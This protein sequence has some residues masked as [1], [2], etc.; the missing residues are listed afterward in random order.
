VASCSG[1]WRSSDAHTHGPLQHVS[2]WRLTA[3]CESCDQRST[4]CRGSLTVTAITGGTEYAPGTVQRPIRKMWAHYRRFGARVGHAPEKRAKKRASQPIA[5]RS[6]HLFAVLARVL[7]TSHVVS[8]PTIAIGRLHCR[9]TDLTQMLF[10]RTFLNCQWHC[11]PT[12][13][14]SSDA[15]THGP[16]QHVNCW[17][18]DCAL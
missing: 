17:R 15:H 6:C 1:G 3:F 8:K 14:C 2:C 13:W 11:A 7:W 10:S 5:T 9:A 4:N 12:T 16:L 18:A